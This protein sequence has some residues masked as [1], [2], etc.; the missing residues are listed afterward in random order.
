MNNKQWLV[1]ITIQSMKWQKMCCT[2]CV[3]CVTHH[4]LC[5]TQLT[6]VSNHLTPCSSAL[7]NDQNQNKIIIYIWHCVKGLDLLLLKYICHQA[8]L[9]E[10][11][12]WVLGMLPM[13][14]VVFISLLMHRYASPSVTTC[15]PSPAYTCTLSAH[16][17]ST[18]SIFHTTGED[19]SHLSSINFFGTSILYYGQWIMLTLTMMTPSQSTIL[20]YSQV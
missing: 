4:A 2:Q 19:S 14:Y 6:D 18:H 11:W 15:C 16:V 17:E 5:T 3:M 9:E 13:Q 12:P 7:G 8:P 20:A 10:G 1:T